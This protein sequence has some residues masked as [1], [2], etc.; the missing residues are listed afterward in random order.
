MA[1]LRTVAYK[2]LEVPEEF[3]DVPVASFDTAD[4]LSAILSADDAVSKEIDADVYSSRR[5]M[6]DTLDLIFGATEGTA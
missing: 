2:G 6:L 4:W 5:M 3:I 1:G